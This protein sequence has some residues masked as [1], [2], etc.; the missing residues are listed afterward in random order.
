MVKQTIAAACVLMVSILFSGCT[1]VKG[2]EAKVIIPGPPEEPRLV[3]IDSYRGESDFVKEMSL[4]DAVI[5]EEMAGGGRNMKK[6]YA[7]GGYGGKIYVTD[8]GAAVVFV[9]DP[10]AKQVSMIG[11]K[12]GGKLALPVGVAFDNNGTVYISDSKI[13]RIYAYDQN[14]TFLREIGSN[15]E[16]MRPTGIA[17]NS[18]LGLLYATDTLGH[19]IKIFTLDGRFVSSFGKRGNEEGEFNYPTNID[20]D[21]RNGNIVVGDTQ[22]FRIQIFDKNG[23]FIS[24]F[25]KIGDKP[26]MFARPKGIAIDSEGHIYVADAAFN[27]IQVFNDKGELMMYFGGA[28]NEPA[29]FQLPATLAF[30][31]EDR[32]YTTEAFNPRVQ[33]FQYISEK[34]KLAHPEEYKKLKEY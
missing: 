14:G 24:K 29:T 27:N 7:V 2:P 17:V 11:D 3:Y 33:V 8:T 22:N 16:F 19:N 5:G 30:D 9:L 26:G 21:R 31:A 23:K 34:W 28:G 32:L 20:V 15:D 4:L 1:P 25:G 18:D 13:K 10:V 12:Q 6:P